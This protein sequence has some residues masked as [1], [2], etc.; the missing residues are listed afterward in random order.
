MA[1]SPSP[2]HLSSRAPGLVYR[3]PHWLQ[4]NQRGSRMKETVPSRG[5]DAHGCLSLPPLCS[6][7]PAATLPPTSGWSAFRSS[8]SYTEEMCAAGERK[9]DAVL[10]LRESL[11]S[12]QL[13]SKGSSAGSS[14]KSPNG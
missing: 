13:D 11:L 10:C 8:A 12:W 7:H 9:V 5:G 2:R 14:V 3:E 4:H 6:E 1:N